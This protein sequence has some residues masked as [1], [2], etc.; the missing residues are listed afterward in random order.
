MRVKRETRSSEAPG[1]IAR[2]RSTNHS[3]GRT[4]MA[5]LKTVVL[6]SAS[7]SSDSNRRGGAVYPL[8][9]IRLTVLRRCVGRGKP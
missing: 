6:M 7:V 2:V 9:I 4:G 3:T 5:T 1:A 8:T